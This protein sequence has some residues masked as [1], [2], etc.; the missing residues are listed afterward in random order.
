MNDGIPELA[1]LDIYRDVPLSEIK[2]RTDKIIN[3][4]IQAKSQLMDGQKMPK[5]F[6]DYGKIYCDSKNVRVLM[7]FLRQ[8]ARQTNAA[9]LCKKW[10]ALKMGVL[11][12]TPHTGS[13]FKPNSQSTQNKMDTKF[14]DIIK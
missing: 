6:K 3:A 4:Y 14:R 11:L 5:R 10:A 12:P 2:A 1:G 13:L 9:I 7:A 8:A